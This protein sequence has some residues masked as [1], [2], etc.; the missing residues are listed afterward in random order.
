MLTPPRSV[1]R[2][3]LPLFTT[4]ALVAISFIASI[5]FFIASRP[6]FGMTSL[7]L[8]AI[9]FLVLFVALRNEINREAKQGNV[10][11]V[12]VAP[13]LEWD[14]F[15]EVNGDFLFRSEPDESDTVTSG[16]VKAPGN[17]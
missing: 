2:V 7:G 1:A 16:G 14:E 9:G 11:T 6:E 12:P 4:S 13:K 15:A 17:S 5:A 3:V 10:Q 8:S